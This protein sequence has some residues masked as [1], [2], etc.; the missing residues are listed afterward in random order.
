MRR[1]QLL[2]VSS[3]GNG[4]KKIGNYEVVDL[5]LSN[6]LLF[7]TCNVGASKET[8][9]GNYYM[10]GKGTRTYSSSDSK[11]E[12]T[13]NPLSSVYDTATKVM[14]IGW[15]MPKNTELQDLIDNT[16]YEWVTN[17]N[18]SGKNGGIF[19]SK[20]NPKAYVF[21]PAAGDYY[22]GSLYDVG[23]YGYVWSSS[24]YDSSRAY[25]LNFYSGG[26]YTDYLSRGDGF[27]VRGVHAAV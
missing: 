19:I 12:G 7:A 5:G 8:D 26:K 13:E 21:F 10:Y 6:G 2:S 4:R 1:R 27:S 20:T 14:G 15:R 11:Y 17:F 25:L 24:P 3:G 18:G 16:D 22:N 9:Y 23:S